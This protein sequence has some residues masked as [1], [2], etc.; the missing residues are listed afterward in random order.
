MIL[1]IIAT[2][3]IILAFLVAIGLIILY[4][5]MKSKE[6]PELM[7]YA[8]V[9]NFLPQFTDG[10][11]F[12]VEK[13]CEVVDRDKMLITYIPQDLTKEQLDRGE[14]KEHSLIVPR[15][16]RLV[17]NKGDSKGRPLFIYC[18]DTKK[19]IPVQL[20]KTIFGDFMQNKINSDHEIEMVNKYQKG[21]RSTSL[22][23]MENYPIEVVDK[24]SKR[25]KELFIALRDITKGGGEM[26]KGGGTSAAVME[27][28]N[29]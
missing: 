23:I 1:R 17:L 8:K 25:M 10:S 18:C 14:L 7:E 24:Y 19:E 22:K 9:V 2:V 26:K 20:Q 16:K 29:R 15:V 5:Y 3:L 21:I 12:G 13:K 4:F 11:I 28:L 6:S 27:A